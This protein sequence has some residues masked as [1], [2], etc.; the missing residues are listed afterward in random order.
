MSI[1]DKYNLD[2]LLAQTADAL[3]KSV[4]A[5]NVCSLY[6]AS[7]RSNSGDLKATCLG[8]IVRN[9]AQVRANKAEWE[10]LLQDPEAIDEIFGM[11]K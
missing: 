2:S 11:L 1:A 10:K 3:S 6:L 8:F 9:Q 5:S 7:R 4:D